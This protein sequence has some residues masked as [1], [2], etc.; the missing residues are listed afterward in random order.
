MQIRRIQ[1]NLIRAEVTKPYVTA[2]EK[3]G[4]TEVRSVLVRLTTEDGLTGVGET[5]PHPGFTAESPDSVMALICHRIGPALLGM[6]AGSINALLVRMDEAIPGN[7]FAKAPFDI[8]AFDLL[9]QALNVPVYQLLGGKVRDRIPM[10]WPF[11]GGAPAENAAEATAK[12]AEGYGSLHIKVGALGPD[13][14]VARVAAVRE[15][16]GPHIPIMIDANQ[17]WDRSTAIRTIQ[18][19][20][21]YNPSMV[22]QPVPSWDMASMAAVQ[23]A[24]S[25]PISADEVID[26]PHKVMDLIRQDAAR[27]FSLKHGKM[28]GLTRARQIAAMAEAAG[29]PC[30][31]NSMIELGVSVAA[32]LHLAATVPNLIDHGHALMSNLRMKGDILVPGSFHYDGKDILVPD[33]CAGLGIRLDE[34]EVARRTLDS[35]TL[36]M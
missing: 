8:A 4:M 20:A 15:A 17:A 2:I 14:D 31:V 25:V 11:G 10:I 35:F 32:S 3:G 1:V 36:E 19:M 12:I 29:I 24:V 7:P 23:A 16:V 6:D 9:G 5:N 34:D 27:I 33:H 22:E 18:R 13:T 21:V 26:S 30:F 28:G